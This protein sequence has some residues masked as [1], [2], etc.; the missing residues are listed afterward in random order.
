[1]ESTRQLEFA[2]Q[3]PGKEVVAWKENFGVLQEVIFE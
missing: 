1:M 3:S 2:G